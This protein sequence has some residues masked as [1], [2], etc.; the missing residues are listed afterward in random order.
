MDGPGGCFHAERDD[1]APVIREVQRIFF[2]SSSRLAGDGK[3][4]YSN[5][6]CTTLATVAAA[7]TTSWAPSSTQCAQR[8]LALRPYRWPVIRSRVVAS[9]PS[10]SAS[11]AK[12]ATL[13]PRP[14]RRLAKSY[15][16]SAP[17]RSDGP[18]IR[19]RPYSSPD[20]SATGSVENGS[21]ACQLRPNYY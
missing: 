11:F 6:H 2:S 18:W 16:S 20:Y 8:P 12:K 17:S 4:S 7:P 19:G 5:A 3:T 10:K 13:S 15:I 14:S 1:Q 21:P 9:G